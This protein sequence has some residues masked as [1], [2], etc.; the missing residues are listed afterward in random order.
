MRRLSQ[1]MGVSGPVAPASRWEAGLG[2]GA[3]PPEPANRHK[4]IPRRP[5][6]R[7]AERQGCLRG[8]A[9]SGQAGCAMAAK[10]EAVCGSL[11]TRSFHL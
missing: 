9:L 2:P 6:T 11:P 3:G 10:Q 5:Q 8:L 4:K 1:E 7:V